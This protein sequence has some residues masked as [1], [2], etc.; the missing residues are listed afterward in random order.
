MGAFNSKKIPTFLHN[1]VQ[2]TTKQR[3]NYVHQR[4][5]NDH[6]DYVGASGEI[7][8]NESGDPTAATYDIWDTVGDE[9]PV[10]YSV[11]FGS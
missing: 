2:T 10:L 3:P 5:N 9:N 8:L 11:D 4:P 7:E 1:S 6:V